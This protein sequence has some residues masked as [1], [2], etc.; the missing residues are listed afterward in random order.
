MKTRVQV[1]VVF[2]IVLVFLMFQE[3]SK[4][5]Y[6]GRVREYDA[7]TLR[8]LTYILVISWAI[9]PIM[10]LV[11]VCACMCA[12]VFIC[13]TLQRDL[14]TREAHTSKN[15]KACAVASNLQRCTPCTQGLV[16]ATLL[17]T[18]GSTR[19]R[20]GLPLYLL[21]LV[22]RSCPQVGQTGT[23]GAAFDVEV[24]GTAVADVVAKLAFLLLLVL[25]LPAV[26]RHRTHRTRLRLCTHVHRIR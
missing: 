25:R 23:S 18:S 11:R 10:W 13:N 19:G 5:D 12:R 22:A 24:A 20:D 7:D 9:F 8:W 16:L 6:G 3:L 26:R 4:A 21:M 15:D 17:P 14:G 2:F 1:A